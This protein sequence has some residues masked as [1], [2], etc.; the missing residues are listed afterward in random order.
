KSITRTVAASAFGDLPQIQLSSRHPDK[1]HN[2]LKNS[3]P[4]DRL[5]PPVPLD[6][7]K[8]ST[9]SPAFSGADVVISLVGVLTGTPKSFE[10]IQFKGAE[11]VARATKDVGAKLIHFS[12]IGANSQSHIMYAKTKGLAE[13][14]VLRICP[15]ATIIRP[16]LVFGPEDD[17]FNRF[18]RLSKFLPFLPVFGG[19]TSRFQ[20]VYVDDLAR[21]V[22]IIVRN[23]PDV[24]KLV[25]GKIIEA[26]GPEAPLHKLTMA[27]S[28][29]SKTDAGVDT[30]EMPAPPTVTTAKV[31]PDRPFSIFTSREKWFIVSVVAFAGLFSPL[32]SNIYFPAIPTISR[33]FNKSTELINLTVTMYIV[34]QGLAPMVW[35]PVSD[36][37][38]RRPIFL[39]CLFILSLTCVGL[40]LVPVSA[41]WLLM[42]LRCIQA[43]GS[44]STIALGAGVIG[45]ISTPKERGGFFGMFT[46]GPMIGPAIGPV[47][48]GALSQH[49]GWRSIFWFICIAS[50]ACLVVLVLFL[51]ETLRSLVGDGSVRPSFIHRPIIPVIKSRGESCYESIPKAKTP[52]N[53]FLLLVNVDII[54]LLTLTAIVCAVYYGFTATVSTLYVTAYPFLSQT[55]IGLCFL[56]IGGGM[57]I[58]STCN[59]KLLDWEYRR[60]AKKATKAKSAS[61]KTQLNEVLAKQTIAENFPIEQISS[62]P[63][64]ASD[65]PSYF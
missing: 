31:E 14:S 35:G 29:D 16:S 43:A 10:E 6:V 54:I 26:G 2:I 36:I 28:A 45:D 9:L 40:A 42:L 25:A 55:E 63:G 3:I 34:M 65:G 53:P 48:G 60:F 30:H 58:G 52:R 33:A 13:T 8:P 32:T 50:S 22:E 19:G 51:P 11:N 20:P 17:F 27:H 4:E 38:G 64:S 62:S 5:L 47:L 59:G 56:A 21:I 7:T 41:Y 23:D 39:A 1:L 61:E 49:L 57:V 37:R 15:D 12:A 24:R 46:I 18:S 44:A